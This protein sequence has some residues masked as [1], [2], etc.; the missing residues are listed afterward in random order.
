ML[1]LAICDDESIHRK[2]LKDKITA[3]SL[4]YDVD[5]CYQEFATANELIAAPFTYDILFLDIKL[6]NGINGI[7]VGCKLREKGN[8]CIIVLV[9]SLEQYAKQGYYADV[10]RY[11]VKPVSRDELSEALNACIQKI[12]RSKSK[13]QVKCLDAMHY[14]NI[15]DIIFIESCNRKRS[16]YTLNQ[17]YETWET[18][19]TL[20]QKL[21]TPQFAYPN[22][23]FIVNLDDIRCEKMN[24]IIMEN[25]KEISI[26]RNCL[27][28]FMIA[29]HKYVSLKK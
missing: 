19:E 20:F 7:D 9:T 10:F 26:S 6:E 16:I 11:I 21:S 12:R 14:F 23:S 25:G 29:L 17:C 8:D 13:I 28:S 4:Q 1:R 3:F 24:V 5:F 2:I 27:K 18:L 15:E 22:Q